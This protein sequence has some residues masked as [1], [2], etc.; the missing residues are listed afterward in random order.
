MGAPFGSWFFG[1]DPGREKRNTVSQC[2]PT[3]AKKAPRRR[4]EMHGHTG[5]DLGTSE[6]RTDSGFR[7][8]GV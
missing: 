4:N 7:D 8:T 6:L 1:S 2:L 3:F 5:L